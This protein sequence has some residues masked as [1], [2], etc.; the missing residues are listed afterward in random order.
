VPTPKESDCQRGSNK[1][2]HNSTTP[3][4]AAAQAESDTVRTPNRLLIPN[5]A[6]T[7]PIV[8]VTDKQDSTTR[9]RRRG[10]RSVR[11]RRRRCR[12]GAHRLRRHPLGRERRA[13]ATGM[14]STSPWCARTTRSYGWASV[15]LAERRPLNFTRS[16]HSIK[17]SFVSKTF[18]KEMLG[19]V[20]LQWQDGMRRDDPSNM[21]VWFR[22]RDWDITIPVLSPVIPQNWRDERG[23]QGTS[24]SWLSHN[25]THPYLPRWAD[26]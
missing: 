14:V 15:L 12:P 25:Q 10:G 9:R 2:I 22:V 6:V 13:T 7:W 24:L 1:G 26:W 19:C 3:I 16:E 23:R 20:W 11:K 4:S 18:Q 8:N 5:S 21:I 17:F